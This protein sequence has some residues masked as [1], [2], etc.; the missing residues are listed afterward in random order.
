G[1]DSPLPTRRPQAPPEPRRQPRHKC[2]AA[3]IC[4]TCSPLWLNSGTWAAPA[5]TF[6][7]PAAEGTAEAAQVRGGGGG[8]GGGGVFRAE[9]PPNASF[10]CSIAPVNSLGMT[11]TLFASPWAIWG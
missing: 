6:P 1:A 2:Q 8:G 10:S 11:Q 7:L 9:A 4:A 3:Q 5:T